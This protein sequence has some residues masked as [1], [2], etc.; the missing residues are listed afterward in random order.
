MAAAGTSSLGSI[1]WRE[2]FAQE[3]VVYQSSDA[4]VLDEPREVDQEELTRF[5]KGTAQTWRA[6]KEY[7][8]ETKTSYGA[9]L[10]GVFRSYLYIHERRARLDEEVSKLDFQQ[11][12]PFLRCPSDDKLERTLLYRPKCSLLVLN[13]QGRHKRVKEGKDGVVGA[14]RYS[15]IVLALNLSEPG[16]LYAV[17]SQS[18]QTYAL[19]VHRRMQHVVEGSPHLAQFLGVA[20]WKSKW[21]DLQTGA[22]V[23]KFG[24]VMPLY[25]KGDLTHQKLPLSGEDLKK[26]ALGMAEGL[27]ALHTKGIIHCDFKPANIFIKEDGTSV[28]GDF[29]NSI[30]KDELATE[31]PF[32]S[33]L[34][35]QAPEV[36]RAQLMWMGAEARG[37]AVL[38]EKTDLFALGMVFWEV[39]EVEFFGASWPTYSKFFDMVTSTHTSTG[40]D[41]KGSLISLLGK[42]PTPEDGSDTLKCIIW[43]TL[44]IDPGLRPA[45]AD[46]L[47]RL[48]ALPDTAFDGLFAASSDSP[49]T[50]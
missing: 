37:R 14:G 13:K 22:D 12:N 20:L 48:N 21:P 8:T 17:G 7:E 1:G 49:S 33:T 40:K 41:C 23:D 6:L 5:Y 2:I 16:T 36:A 26:C 34:L 35:Y 11:M 38:G 47:K 44:Q 18:D 24:T 45:S 43:D 46:V 32:R 29:S 4:P 50:R 3:G 25:R 27:V 9:T 28:V 30:R 31:T 19:P 39:S 10:L 42:R 15:K